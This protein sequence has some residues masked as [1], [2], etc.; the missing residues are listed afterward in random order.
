LEP[1]IS[2]DIDNG[3]K[4]LAI[5]CGPDYNAFKYYETKLNI[6]VIL[7]ELGD[8]SGQL[9]GATQNFCEV[10]IKYAGVNYFWK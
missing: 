8:V 3:K 10:G 9:L 4:G 7:H 1:S 2:R 5:G 6:R